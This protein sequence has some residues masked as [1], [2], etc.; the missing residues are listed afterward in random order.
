MNGQRNRTNAQ[1][2]RDALRRA[3]DTVASIE[4]LWETVP[5][6]TCIDGIRLPPQVRDL[7]QVTRLLL[8]LVAAQQEELMALKE[9]LGS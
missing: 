8:A 4:D 9:R 7:A 6:R 2:L 3:E 5:P 1:P